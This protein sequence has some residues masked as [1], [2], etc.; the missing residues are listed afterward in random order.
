[1][2]DAPGHNNVLARCAK[3]S[4][5]DF[6]GLGHRLLS[7]TNLVADSSQGVA[8]RTPHGRPVLEVLRS[9]DG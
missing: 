6:V 5:L 7:E 8:E 4:L 3:G 2:R 1:M 9:A